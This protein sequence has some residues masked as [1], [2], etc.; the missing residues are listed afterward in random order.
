MGIIK[1][2]GTFDPQDAVDFQKQLDDY[3]AVLSDLDIDPTTV[4]SKAQ[5]DAILANADEKV[6]RMLAGLP[7]NHPLNQ[8]KGSIEGYMEH[9]DEARARK[10]LEVA[11]NRA[12]MRLAPCGPVNKFPEADK[13]TDTPPPPESSILRL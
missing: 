11:L 3:R 6:E 13:S 2:P 8:V 5:L 12:G 1:F 9:R 7:P 10:D 4:R